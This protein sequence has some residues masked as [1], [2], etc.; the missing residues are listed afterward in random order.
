MSAFVFAY[1]VINIKKPMQYDNDDAIP[2][3]VSPKRG[4]PKLP[5]IK[6]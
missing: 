5:N 4:I 1:I 2:A 3:P 6:I